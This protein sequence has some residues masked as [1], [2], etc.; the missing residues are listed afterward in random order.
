MIKFFLKKKDIP[1]IN[2][3]VDV[4]NC[5]S[6]ET[7]LSIGAHDLGKLNGN[8]TLRMT[9]G[10]EYF[11][12]LGSSGAE[13]IHAGEYCYVDDGNEVVCRLECRQSNKTKI[14]QQTENCLIIVQGNE[15]TSDNVILSTAHRLVNLVR[16]YCGGERGQFF[17]YS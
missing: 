3:L 12:P 2:P 15:Y 4:Y 5:V 7:R 10:E 13:K 17:F 14:D 6:M 16:Q 9:T 1:S 8:V 11:L